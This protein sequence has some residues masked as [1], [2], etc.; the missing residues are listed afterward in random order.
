MTPT[1]DVRQVDL[2]R[3]YVQAWEQL[4]LSRRVLFENLGWDENAP[5]IGVLKWAITAELTGETTRFPRNALL[6]LLADL[7]EAPRKLFFDELFQF[8]T[9][10]DPNEG[11]NR[12][13][14][15]LL[16]L[17]REW[18][19]INVRERVDDIL[20]NSPEE[21]GTNLIGF[22]LEIDPEIARKLA[23]SAFASE[24]ET[25]RDIGGHFLQRLNAP[26]ESA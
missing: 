1:P 21:V 22:V 10:F 17:P 15:I 3:L 16:S 26:T 7:P 13:A 24:D 5:I 11:T 12:A 19:T 23:D 20:Q 2:L 6:N 25:Q 14:E 18:L 4:S 8:M 9:D